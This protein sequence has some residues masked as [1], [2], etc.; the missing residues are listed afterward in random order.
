M[1]KETALRHP[2]LLRKTADSN[3]GES[4]RAQQICPHS[5]DTA[6]SGWH[7]LGHLHHNSTTVRAITSPG[8]EPVGGTRNRVVFQLDGSNRRIPWS[9]AAGRFARI[10]ISVV[11]EATQSASAGRT[12]TG[13]NVSIGDADSAELEVH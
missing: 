5:K 10:A 12:Y 13:R 9:S 8:F 2:R 1:G 3:A 4:G 11:D 7:L 6:A